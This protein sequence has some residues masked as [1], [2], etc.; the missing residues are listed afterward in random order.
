MFKSYEINKSTIL[1]YVWSSVVTFLTGFCVVLLAQ[2]DDIT[3]KSFTD[4]SIAGVVFAG[5]RGGVKALIELF[6]ARVD[7]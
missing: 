4:G 7:K 6:L 1:R 5:L 3:L 2:W